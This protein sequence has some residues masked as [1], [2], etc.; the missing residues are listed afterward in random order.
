MAKIG[1][2]SDLSRIEELN[3]LIRLLSSWMNEVTPVINGKIEFDQNIR[4]QTVS[5]G[6][7]SANTDTTVAHKLNK[8]GVNFLVV[9]K[10]AACD[11][12][13]G[14]GTDTVNQIYLRS[15]VAGVTV[16]LTLL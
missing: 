4:S 7:P 12:Y 6:F 8:T 2:Q 11:I 5:V 3:D 1:A 14:A 16:T 9:N 10:T 15:S 13:H